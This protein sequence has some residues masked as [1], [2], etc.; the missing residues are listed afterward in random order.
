MTNNGQAKKILL[1]VGACIQ[2]QLEINELLVGKIGRLESELDE[3]EQSFE[4]YRQYTTKRFEA[5]IR[6]LAVKLD[7]KERDIDY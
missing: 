5:I 1:K 6:N 7:M 2:E 4:S 3:M